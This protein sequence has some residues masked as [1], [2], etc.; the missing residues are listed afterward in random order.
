MKK[1]IDNVSVDCIIFGFDN[2]ELKVM[3][4]RRDC[5][6]P[7]TKKLIFSDYTLQGHH[8]YYGESLEEAAKR[9]LKDKTGLE[10][11]FLEQFKAFGS[12]DRL[13][14]DRDKLWRKH[15]FPH[16]SDHVITVGYLSLVDSNKVKPDAEHPDTSWFSINDLPLLA[17]DHELVLQ[18]ALRTLRSI[19]RRKPI[20]FEL[21]PEKFTL[22]QMQTLYEVVLGVKLDKRNFRKKVTQMKYLI[23]INDKQKNVNHKPAQYYIFSWDVYKKT[24]KRKYNFVT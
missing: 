4:T 17:F 21:L 23:P 6:D 18:K 11:I 14:S 2:N 3:L 13:G 15:V 12:L 24:K 19:F 9:V 20:G 10:N 22:H 5:H 16:V 1:L 8:I 7:V